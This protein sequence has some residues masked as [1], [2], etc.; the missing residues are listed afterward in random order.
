MDSQAGRAEEARATRLDAPVSTQAAS[1]QLNVATTNFTN[2]QSL[3]LNM[4]R[5]PQI[6]LRSRVLSVSA[7]GVWSAE[8]P[9]VKSSRPI[10]FED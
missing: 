2:G 9:R 8:S 6:Q 5:A 4:R 10:F 3:I 7:I 1:V